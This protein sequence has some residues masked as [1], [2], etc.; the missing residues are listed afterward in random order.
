MNF[1]KPNLPK[2]PKCSAN[3]LM[4]DE[5]HEC[6][7]TSRGYMKTLFWIIYLSFCALIVF[8]AIASCDHCNEKKS[9]VCAEK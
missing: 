8:A 5:M 7:E 3:I 6:G 4:F 9:A 1:R 2:C